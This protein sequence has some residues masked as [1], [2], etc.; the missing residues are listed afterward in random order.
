MKDGEDDDQP[1]YVVEDSRN[2]ISKEEYEVLVKGNDAENQGGRE[3]IDFPLFP[4][5]GAIQI[6]ARA[7]K[8]ASPESSTSMKQQAAAIG[9]S[10]KRRL[11]KI[12]GD[13]DEEVGKVVKRN[14]AE[15]KVKHKGKQGKKVK[16]TFDDDEANQS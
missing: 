15:L 9:A 5:S 1:T 10:K 8:D 13:E 12:V 2:T 7:G 11:A 3:L 6:E 4:K 14:P 16:L